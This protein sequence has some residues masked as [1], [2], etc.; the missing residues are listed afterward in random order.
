MGL[1]DRGILDGDLVLLSPSSRAKEGDIVATRHGAE[2]TFKSFD[3]EDS[4]ILGVVC[5]V[6]RPLHD[7]ERGASGERPKDDDG[8]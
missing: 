3:R 8:A 7:Q 6:F 2:A 5:G 1:A 4:T